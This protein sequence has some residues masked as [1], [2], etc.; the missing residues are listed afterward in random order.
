MGKFNKRAQGLP[1]TVIVI[2]AL[3]LMVLVVLIVI[4]SSQTGKTVSTLQ[5]C[6]GIA[7]QCREK[8]C[9]DGEIPKSNTKCSK[10]TEI[11]CIKI[12]EEKK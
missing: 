2:A 11:C 9:L 6:E 1:I 10:A 5:S 3:S 4:F 7:G 12:F 8:T